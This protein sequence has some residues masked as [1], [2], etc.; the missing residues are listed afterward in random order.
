MQTSNS[1]IDVAALADYF[2]DVAACFERAAGAVGRRTHTRKVGPLPFC[3]EFAGPALEPRMAPAFGHLAAVD[4]APDLCILLWDAQSTGV[5]PPA[6]PWE[7]GEYVRNEVYIGDRIKVVYKGD[8]GSLIMYD[9]E[10]RLAIFWVRE[11]GNIPFYETG[12]PLLPVMHWWLESRGCQL[13]HAG[14]VGG[15]D[16]GVLLVG[17]GGS[18]KS[19]TALACLVGGFEYAA[20]DYCVLAGTHPARVYSLYCSAKLAADTRDRLPSLAAAIYN[21]G[22]ASSEKTLYFLSR[23]FP[24]QV[25]AGFPL[26]AVLLPRV[27]GTDATTLMPV[28]PAVALRALAPSTIFQLAGAGGAALR[29]MASVIRRVPCFEIAVGSDL[30]RIP[31]AIRTFL[32]KGAVP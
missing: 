19:T 18:G 2:A 23:I 14:A 22:A 20:D 7:W 8:S 30:S 11:A 13:A 27:A 4:A 12:A 25:S 29:A 26:R 1:P 16:G 9:A 32:Q 31:V 15:P 10:A 17:R 6:P 28:S 3:L 21:S 5:V 24:E